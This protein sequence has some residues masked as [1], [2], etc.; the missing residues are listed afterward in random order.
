MKQ[1]N[2]TLEGKYDIV[3]MPAFSYSLRI[4]RKSVY[5]DVFT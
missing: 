1:A 4:S 5:E 3:H 2:N